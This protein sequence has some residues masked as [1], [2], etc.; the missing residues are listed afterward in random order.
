MPSVNGLSHTVRRSH[1]L[2]AAC[3]ASSHCPPSSGSL[4]RRGSQV[5]YVETIQRCSPTG[6]FNEARL[7]MASYPQ[8]TEYNEVVQHPATAFI[9]AELQKGQVKENALGLP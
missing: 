7:L 5:A 3:G 1:P 6:D 8:M 4:L 2:L 9:D